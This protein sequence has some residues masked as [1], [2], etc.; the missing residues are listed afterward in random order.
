MRK[1]I[2]L[3]STIILFAAMGCGGDDPAPVTCIETNC[4]DYISQAAA[5]AAFDADP[6]CHN[7]LDWDNDGIPCEEPGNSVTT[8]PTTAACG[9]SN[10]TK[11]QCEADPCCRWTVGSGCGC[12]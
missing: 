2:L 12:R 8:C 4:A 11:S 9:C 7:D 1:T 10:H 3:F 5:Q 6:E